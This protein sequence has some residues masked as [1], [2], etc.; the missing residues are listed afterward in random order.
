MIFEW[1]DAPFNFNLYDSEQ[2]SIENRGNIV[3]SEYHSWAEDEIIFP[4]IVE[5]K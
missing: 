5:T 3:S 2:K 4:D 1:R